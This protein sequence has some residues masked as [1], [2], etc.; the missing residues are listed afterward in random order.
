MGK[1]LD[2]IGNRYGELLVVEMLYNYNNKNKTYC[3]CINDNN[4][5]VIVRQD[6][7]RNGSTK[8]VNGSKNK[9]KEKDLT[10]LIV[11]R[12]KV[13][14]KTNTKA[15]NGFNIW[16]CQCECGNICYVSAGDLIRKRKQSCGCI[17]QEYYDSLA[18]DIT[19]IRFGMLTAVEYVGKR[20]KPGNYRRLWKCK[21][22][23]GNETFVAVSDL[24]TGNTMS[25]GCQNISHGEFYIKT[26]L[27]ENN[28]KFEPQYK[29]DN[30]KNKFKLPFDFYL[31]DYNMCIEY[32][33]LQHYRPIE[34]FGGNEGFLKRQE[35]DN[36]KTNYCIEHSIQLIRIPY[37]WS[38]KEINN[39]ILN[40]LS[41]V[42]ITE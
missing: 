7:L 17:T 2:L 19:G 18:L 5:E 24:S 11:G 28:I 25:C 20:G 39:Y 35:N 3:R 27:E 22:D 14:Q 31:P 4:E 6:A 37:N 42:T 13:I 36:I 9:G 33:G 30:C 16:E 40:I 26:I 15:A 8:T 41:P 1:R 12:L 34:R 23:C 10:N 32:D 21:C 29:F 38:K